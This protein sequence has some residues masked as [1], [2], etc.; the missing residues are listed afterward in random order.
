LFLGGEAVGAR[1]A[2]KSFAIIGDSA[3]VRLVLNLEYRADQ[4]ESQQ[5]EKPLRLYLNKKRGK[6]RIKGFNTT[7]DEGAGGEGEKP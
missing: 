5:L 1:I 4:E 7:M 3:E 6:W 2:S